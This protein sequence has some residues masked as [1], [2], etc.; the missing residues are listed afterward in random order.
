MKDANYAADQ[1]GILSTNISY[2]EAE[3]T[4]IVLSTEGTDLTTYNNRIVFSMNS[5]ASN[6]QVM[7]IGHDSIGGVGGFEIVQNSDLESFGRG[8]SDKAISLIDAKTPPSG[9]FPV[10]LDPE[11][12][13]VFIHEAVGHASEA[14]II[15]QN[16]SILKDK[17]G[18]KIGSDLIT[19]IDDATIKEGFGYYPYDV[20]GTKTRKNILIENGVMTYE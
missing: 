1:E 2:S 5:V 14:D 7:Q 15:L 20:E 12:A 8:I 11:L 3:S 10:I 19:V 9:K 13:G 4:N 17:L 16:D 6:G 18:Q